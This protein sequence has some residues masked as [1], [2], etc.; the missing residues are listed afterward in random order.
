MTSFSSIKKLSIFSIFLV[1]ILYTWD[2]GNLDAIRQ[3]T[4]G[5]YLQIAKEMFNA[6]S[7]LTPLYNGENHWSKPPL[8][9]WMANIFYF[10]GG[11]PSIL[12]SRLSIVLFSLA[13]LILT[14]QIVSKLLSKSFLLI[15]VFLSATFGMFK[16][17]RIFMM[18]MPLTM[19]TTLGAL[20]FYLYLN[21]KKYSLHLASLFIGLSILVKGPVSIVMAVG[22]I[23]LF[24]VLE[25]YMF[26]FNSKD[27]K[28]ALICFF[29]S[30]AIASIWF[31]ICTLKYGHEFID[32]FFLRENL[33]KF[34]SKS[35]PIRHVFQGLI[36]FALPWSLYLPIS[37]SQIK[38][39]WIKVKNDKFL[40]FSNCCF[41]VF[42]TLW[43][44]PSQRSHHYAMPS[45]IFFLISN[46][47]LLNNYQLSQKREK[48]MKLAN[49]VI[50]ILMALTG[51]LLSSLLVFNEVNQSAS[52]TIK[53][54]TTVALLFVGAFLFIKSK[55]QV[56]KYFIALFIIGNLWNIFIPSFI[57]PYM[58]DRVI[59]T[60]GS[61]QV[62]ASVRKPYFIEEALERKINWIG[63]HSIRQYILENNHYY[64]M[65]EATYRSNKLEDLTNVVTTW[66]VWRRGVKAKAG[67]NA[68]LNKNIEELKDTVYLL[69]N[70]PLR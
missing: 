18:E 5:F 47:I 59:K 55:K 41:F 25:W 63:S 37:I 1:F 21:D 28:K 13:T 49:I 23:G 26:G 6:G 42:F 2:I 39:H 35:Y 19:L 48:M 15:F 14:S 36:I 11:G 69:E 70:K 34:A 65:H 30:L 68:L 29:Y 53:V 17:S 40:L 4:E 64:I 46:F 60:I 38:D 12:L 24:L 52:L 22:G 27:L 31:I 9:F 56:S 32:Y 54:L 66:K 51:I 10:I 20:Y 33:G 62:S 58:P 67:V 50:S 3:G 57:L 45:I 44:I 8:Q 7:I 61:A 16:Y 43:L